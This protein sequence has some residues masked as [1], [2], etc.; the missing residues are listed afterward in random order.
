M[1]DNAQMAKREHSAVVIVYAVVS[2]RGKQK[3][4]VNERNSR[5]LSKAPRLTHKEK[6]EK[7]AKKPQMYG[8]L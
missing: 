4:K 3:L 5:G 1:R 7:S 8:A 6:K 2:P